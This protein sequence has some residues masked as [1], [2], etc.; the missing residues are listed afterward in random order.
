LTL[1]ES[2]WPVGEAIRVAH[3][4][5]K[6]ANTTELKGALRNQNINNEIQDTS[7]GQGHL[8]HEGARMR[9]LPAEYESGI[10]TSLTISGSPDDVFVSN[11]SGKIF[12]MHEQTMPPIDMALG[13]DIEIVNWFEDPFHTTTN[14]NTLDLDSDG[15]TLNNRWFSLVVWVI[16]NKSGETS[17]LMCNLPSGSYTSEAS[18]VSDALGYSNYTIPKA[19]KGVSVLTARFTMRKSNV[20][21]TFN[22]LVG[23]QDLR[24]FIPNTTAGS[25]AGSSGITTFTGLLDTPSAYTSSTNRLL[26]ENDGGTA[27]EFL[28]PTTDW[29][30]QYLP[31]DGSRDMTGDLDMNFNHIVNASLIES[32]G[33]QGMTINFEEDDSDDSSFYLVGDAEEF[34]IAGVDAGDYDSMKIG[35]LDGTVHARGSWD[36]AADVDMNGMN[37]DDVGDLEVNGQSTFTSTSFP[38]IDVVRDTETSV[39]NMYAGARITRKMTGGTPIDGSG[40]G[41]FFS[42]ADDADQQTITGFLGGSLADVTNGAEVGEI[43]ISPAWQGATSI[44][45]RDFVVKATSSTE[46]QIYTSG[47]MSI[48]I[49]ENNARLQVEGEST[50]DTFVLVH[51]PESATGT[52]AGIKF[53]TVVSNQNAF[54]KSFIAHEES[55][56]WGYGDMVFCV[57]PNAD[58]SAVDINDEVMRISGTGV[59]ITGDLEVTGDIETGST[60]AF[61]F[62]DQ[63]TDGSW[64]IVRSGNNLNFERRESSVWVA[65]DAMTP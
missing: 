24:G 4:V 11:T 27:L 29:L 46:S 60:K 30:S 63:T 35:A 53:S 15:D 33:G 59:G 39:G 40:I 61:Y 55:G 10:E 44:D 12:Q 22:P 7:T 45:R 32:T 26:Q 5:L 21:F 37:I 43:I 48:G 47:N 17:H 56:A 6:S 65:K 14:L 16:C 50:G 31:I 8:T 38:V 1:S 2:G 42:V 20:S 18:A 9:A 13:E 28:D 52:L 41:F 36:F 3:V 57:D 23:Y 34:I 54:A 62:G 51:S 64:R 58:Q 49:E 25:G 19:Y